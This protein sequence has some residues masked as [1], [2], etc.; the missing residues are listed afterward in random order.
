[1]KS[2]V[3]TTRS[4]N[5]NRDMTIRIYGHEGWPI[6]AF[7][8]QEEMSDSFEKNGMIDSI[9]GYIESGR[10]QV[11]C[12]DTVD[13]EGWTN[14]DGDMEERTAVIE[15]YYNYICDEVVPFVNKRSTSGRRPLTMGVSMGALHALVLVLRRPDLFQGCISL[16][17]VYD[18]KHFFGDWM[19]DT[20]YLNSPVHFLPNTPLDHPY[21]DQYR[22][23]QFAICVGQGDGEQEGIDS[24]RALD[25]A[26][27]ALDV[28]VWC[29]YWGYDVNHDWYWW[30][31]QLPYFLPYVLE[32][33]EKTTA[34]EAAESPAKK[35]PARKAAAKK[36]VTKT[37]TT[38][39]KA[40]AGA[41]KTTAAAAKATAKKA[42]PKAEAA[43]TAAKKTA[44][45]TKAAAK[46]TA[47]KV[48]ADTKKVAEKASADVKAAATKA[49]ADT[50]KVAEK[51]S[52]DV[53]ATAAKAGADAKKT[54]AKVSA[55]VKKAAEKV[56]DDTKAA[57]KKT[58]VKTAEKKP[59]AKPASKTAAKPA[60]K[61]AAK[62]AAKP[63]AK[64]P[65]AKPASKTAAKPTTKTASKTAAKK[66]STK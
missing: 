21:L 43:K 10:V 46:K 39:K 45:T 9:A 29:D 12:V 60:A 14:A 1:M 51:A 63:A 13:S 65:A 19:N 56:A 42:A 8:A 48:S 53:K 31:K 24:E 44:A 11:F 7:P 40:A 26:F 52:A 57:A 6:I 49:S 33:A 64:K 34:Q 2:E 15:S 59:A 3:V 50:K 32:D 41:K 25:A 20:L 62:A 36:A 54:A 66:P 30:Q 27:R 35:R 58:A 18:A 5:L 23:R 61:P 28:D 16:S 4:K 37:A 22:K 17:G 55:D 38:A 47:E